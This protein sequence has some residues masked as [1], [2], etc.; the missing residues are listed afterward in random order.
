MLRADLAAYERAG[1]TQ[2]ARIGRDLLRRAGAP[3][4]RGR[5]DAVVPAALR[6]RGVTS[7]ELDVLRLVDA[8]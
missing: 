2:L 6:A 7:R 8:G 3:I 4:R 5:G 1:E